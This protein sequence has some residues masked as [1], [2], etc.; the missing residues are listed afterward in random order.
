[1]A[2]TINPAIS[3]EAN[4]LELIL[5]ANPDAT[6]TVGDL[7]YGTPVTLTDHPT[8]KNTSVVVSPT[9]NLAGVT[10]S[11]TITY[12]RV[13]MDGGVANADFNFN[14]SNAEITSAE[15]LTQVA[16]ALGLREEEVELVGDVAPPES[17]STSTV[18]LQAK[19]NSLLYVGQEEIT[20][21]WSFLL[22]D[23]ITNTD[24]AGF[25]PIS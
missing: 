25:D 6:F 13:G 17:G 23:M 8:G 16:T 20:I 21:N 3:A 4:V 11:V 1:M 12:N 14:V 22:E 10:G 9:A 18:T 24:M 2:V 5:D 19:A 15:F 7:A